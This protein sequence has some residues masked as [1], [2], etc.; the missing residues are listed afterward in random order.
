MDDHFPHAVLLRVGLDKTLGGI[1]APITDNGPLNEKRE[2]EYVP[3]PHWQ[4]KQHMR[5]RPD[6]ELANYGISIQTYG[7]LPGINHPDRRLDDFLPY[8]YIRKDRERWANPASVVLHNDP[9][10]PSVTYGDYWRGIKRG[11]DRVRT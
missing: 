10:F 1:W 6:S 11:D 8:D 2:F 5:R 4:S 3:F 7:D 9:N